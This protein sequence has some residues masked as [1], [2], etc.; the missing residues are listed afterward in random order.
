MVLLTDMFG[1]T[2]CN[3]AI[4]QM[5][6]HSVEVIAGVNLPMLVKLAKVR[7]N[8]PLAD[9]VDCAA[10]RRAQIHRRRLARAAALPAGGGRLNGEASP[11]ATAAAA[12]PVAAVNGS[13]LRG[14]A[15]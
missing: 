8:Q 6:R 12:A 15:G 13:K 2:P 4:S 14:A 1:G 3:L 5:D 11:S 10:D 7:S 9:A